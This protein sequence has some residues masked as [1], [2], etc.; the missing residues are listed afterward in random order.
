MDFK[1]ED[2]VRP[3][4]FVVLFLLFI[5]VGMVSNKLMDDLGHSM[6]HWFFLYVTAGLA[7]YCAG[8]RFTITISDRILLPVFTLFAFLMSYG[9]FG[10]LSVPIIASILLIYRHWDLI[11]RHCG[12]ISL[13]GILLVLGNLVLVGTLP[14][15]DAG[16][17]FESQTVLLLFG[18]T[19][20]VLGVNYLFIKDPKRGAICAGLLAISITLY[21]FRSYLLILL[22]SLG[23]QSIMLGRLR[24]R[25]MVALAAMAFLV[26]LVGGSLIV[27]NLDQDWHLSSFSLLFYRVGF[28]TH[29]FDLAC[30]A[31]G[32]WGALHGQI[33]T[34]P[35]TSPLIGG[36]LVGNGNITTTIIGPLVLDGGILEV[37]LMAFLGAS[38]NSLYQASK[39]DGVFVPLYSLF[40][41]F[42][43]ISI[44][45]SPVPIYFFI[46]LFVLMVLNRK[47][48]K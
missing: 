19:L 20:A 39:K 16:I 10:L 15:I 13:L 23:I 5:F 30:R 6:S 31:S 40:L 17:R 22:L 44:E 29:M 2:L 12:W 14:V 27:S 45:I 43:L 8:C 28:T 3:Q 35:S 24:M 9:E 34:M 7:F 21:G 33:W 1:T 48:N 37:P 47:N 32:L 25:M 11:E 41:S 42:L 46:L 26:V 4:I 18:Y 36:Y 38:I